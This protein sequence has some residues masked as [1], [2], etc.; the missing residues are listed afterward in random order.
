LRKLIITALLFLLIGLNCAK[1]NQLDPAQEDNISIT[2]N[3]PDDPLVENITA[4]KINITAADLPAPIQDSL[5]ISADRESSAVISTWAPEGQDRLFTLFLLQADGQV[6]FWAGFT[7]DVSTEAGMEFVADVVQAATGSASRIK[8]LRD[9][10]PW[11]SQA[12]DNVLEEIGVTLGTEEFQYIALSSASLDTVTLEAGEDLV[13]IANDQNQEFYNN[14]YVYQSKIEAFVNNGGALF[15]EAC[16]LGWAG[17]SIAQAGIVLPG[18]ISIISGYDSYNYLT[19]SK[20]DLTAGLD[21][22]LYGTYASHEGFA[23]L[24]AGT[25]TYTV[26]S[27]HLPTLISYNLGIGWVFVSGQ[28][29]EYAYDRGDSLNTGSLLPRIIR[30]ILGLDPQVSGK[31]AVFQAFEY[32]DRDRKS[33]ISQ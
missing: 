30:L 9:D 4:L 20:W 13:I 23:D 2:L 18:N 17:G 15:W 12:L 14:Y 11:N 22:T 26:D 16:D 7:G 1:N 29:L 8:I 31:L 21:S 5:P 19:S 3:F 33:G 28:P 24:P 27:R 10:L 25:V 6:T 32:H